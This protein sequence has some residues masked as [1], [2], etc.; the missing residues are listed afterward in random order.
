MSNSRRM[1][2]V[3]QSRAV[4]WVSYTNNLSVHLKVHRRRIAFFHPPFPGLFNNRVCTSATWHLCNHLSHFLLQHHADSCNYTLLEALPPSWTWMCMIVT[5]DD[6]E[7]SSQKI[8]FT[9]RIFHAI[10]AFEE[11]SPI[12][13]EWIKCMSWSMDIQHSEYTICLIVTF[14]GL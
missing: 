8:Y 12:V 10:G 7:G 4:Q 6:I 14:R 9:Y 1:N 13:E 11:P 5:K 2:G 3:C